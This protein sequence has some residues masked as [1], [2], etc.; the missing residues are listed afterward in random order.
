MTNRKIRDTDITASSELDL[1]SSASNARLNNTKSWVAD[2]NDTQ[3]WIQVNWGKIMN[4]TSISTQGFP[5]SGFVS[6]FYFS[7]NVSE[8]EW[9][10]YTIHGGLVKV[11]ICKIT[12]ES[13]HVCYMI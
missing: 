12:V 6:S 7:Y 8:M 4:I 2:T 13:F 1:N 3:P 10:N 11:I 9:L 5:G